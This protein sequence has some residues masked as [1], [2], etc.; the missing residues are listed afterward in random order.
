MPTN[1]AIYICKYINR[2]FSYIDL[3]SLDGGSPV[4]HINSTG[5]LKGVQNFH[6]NIL[7]SQTLRQILELLW[8]IFIRC[9]ENVGEGDERYTTEQKY[10]IFLNMC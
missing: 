3:I 10:N 1:I 9:K 5:T 7:T 6:F 2:V 8:L 4:Y